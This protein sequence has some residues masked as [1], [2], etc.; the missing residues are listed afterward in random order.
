MHYI[1]P[2]TAAIIIIISLSKNYKGYKWE[3]NFGYGTK[4][5]L[6]AIK[7][8]FT[9][10]LSTWPLVHQLLLKKQIHSWH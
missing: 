8:T 4:K 2:A 7:K 9:N 1:W 6:K 5:H 10:N 3:N